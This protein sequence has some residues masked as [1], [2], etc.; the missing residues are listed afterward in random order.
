MPGARATSESAKKD[1]TAESANVIPT[2]R[3]AP[4]TN[5]T[6]GPNAV[7]TYAYGPPVMLTRLPAS[8]KQMT[9]NAIT[10]VQ[11]RYASGAAAPSEAATPEGRR[12]TPPPTVTLTMLA[13]SPQR[14]I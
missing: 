14:P 10:S 5:P 1:D 7:S 6:K 8:A 9:I 2:Q 4:Q 12:N 11:T 13:A 3:S